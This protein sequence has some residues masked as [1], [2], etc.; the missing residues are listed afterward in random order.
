M[1]VCDSWPR[2][3]GLETLMSATAPTEHFDLSRVVGRAYDIVRRNF[4][5]LVGLTAIL[6]GLPK[7]GATFLH[8]AVGEHGFFHFIFNMT[9]GVYGLIAAFGFLALQSAVVHVA[10]ADL[11]DREA[12]IG[13]CL[14][15]GLRFLF[16]I[17]G[18][19]IVTCIGV[20]VGMVLLVVP[21][22][23]LATIWAVSM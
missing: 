8:L 1:R 15:T 16:P 4:V 2:T 22:L 10:A 7:L 21:G 23:I 19:F 6:Y 14:R 20:T 3:A 13:A 17:L 12:N 5:L 9:A 18:L 11:N